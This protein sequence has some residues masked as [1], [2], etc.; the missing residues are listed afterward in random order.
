MTGRRE[1]DTVRGRM[2]AKEFPGFDF[3]ATFTPDARSIDSNGHVNVGYYGVYFDLAADVWFTAQGL[4]DASIQTEKASLFAGETRTKY[5]REV[6]PGGK[7]DIYFRIE[8]LSRKA[9]L[10]HLAM[11]DPENGELNAILE[12]LWL[13]V[14][15]TTRRVAPMPDWMFQSF[16]AAKVRH[17]A[18]TP[19]LPFKGLIAFR[20]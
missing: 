5:L 3:T 19:D 14:D 17:H 2:T 12:C 8:D 11:R 18:A 20:R 16:S 13:S 4:S 7:M 6:M 10:A 9:L 1:L 15:V